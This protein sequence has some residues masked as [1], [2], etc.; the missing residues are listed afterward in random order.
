MVLHMLRRLMGDDAF[1]AGLRDF[2][3]T[4]RYKKA[5]TDDFRVAMEKAVAAG[6]SSASSTAGSSAAPSRRVRFTCSTA[7]STER[8]FASSR[9]ARPLRHPGHGDAA[10]TPTARRR[11]SWSC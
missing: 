1:F 5:G 9:K 2:Y 10:A 7:T 8:G 4:L 11:T 6:R 3:V